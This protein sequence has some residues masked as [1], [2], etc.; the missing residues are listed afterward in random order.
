MSRYKEN[1]RSLFRRMK[2]GDKKSGGGGEKKS[3]GG[4]GKSSGGGGGGGGGGSKSSGGG[5]GGG[6]NKPNAQGTPAQNFANN[7]AAMVR[8]GMPGSN[9]PSGGNNK[10]S[11]NKP[12]ASKPANKPVINARGVPSLPNAQG[13]GGGSK[14][15]GGGGKSQQGKAG[16]APGLQQIFGGGKLTDGEFRQ[17]KA[18]HGHA[19]A[20]EYI[21]GNATP[22]QLGSKLSQRL[23]GKQSMQ[24]F[25]GKQPAPAEPATPAA[26]PSPGSSTADGVK[27][28]TH[29]YAADF[30]AM[31]A[32]L[33][34]QISQLTQAKEAPKPEV[35][36]GG[37]TQGGTGLSKPGY[38]YTGSG[39]SG[40]GAA[41][42]SP[43]LFTSWMANQEALNRA[44]TAY[45]FAPGGTRRQDEAGG[46]AATTGSS[47]SWN[48]F[49]NEQDGER[50]QQAWSTPEADGIGESAE[51]RRRRG[52]FSPSGVRYA[53]SIFDDTAAASSNNSTA[54][55]Y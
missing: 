23:S 18:Q 16:K 25:F 24:G 6:G 48:S 37:I 22:D 39:G 26:P 20:K 33:R 8:S 38:E 1:E 47:T 12:T 49:W 51:E 54:V 29:D 15:A 35:T 45:Q 40:S 14:P 17:A 44:S 32:P 55:N 7:Y 43:S 3:G 21:R 46:A 34:D 28:E 50:V 42:T 53:G 13:G 19:A 31:L 5:G 11:P 2:S 52:R 41:N 4:S 27:P 10:P 36:G 9:K 30:E